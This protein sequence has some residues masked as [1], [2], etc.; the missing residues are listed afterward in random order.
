VDQ[1]FKNIRQLWPIPL[2]RIKK[3]LPA[4]EI[5]SPEEDLPLGQRRYLPTGNTK[6]LTMGFPG[7]VQKTINHSEPTIWVMVG[8]SSWTSKAL[9]AAQVK[10]CQ[11]RRKCKAIGSYEGKKLLFLGLGTRSRTRTPDYGHIRI[12][13]VFTTVGWGHVAPYQ[14]AHLESMW[15]MNIILGLKKKG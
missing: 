15:K 5:F 3:F 2:E 8:E 11:W 10:N 12:N 9:L 13:T 6:P 4:Y 14:K 1:T 7:V